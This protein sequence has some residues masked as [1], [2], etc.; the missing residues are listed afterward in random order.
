M[1]TG[2]LNFKCFKPN[3]KIRNLLSF[4]ELD[5]QWQVEARSN[6]D[7]LCEETQYIEP[8]EH[9]TPAKHILFDLHD[10][11]RTDLLGVDGIMP[12][13]YT[14]LAVR[15]FEEDHDTMIETWNL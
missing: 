3:R 10:T 2:Q 4:W 6:L 9:H 1:T 7:D 12:L 8:E 13:G 15:I 14:G 5:K 11:M